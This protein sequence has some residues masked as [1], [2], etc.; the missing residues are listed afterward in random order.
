M[1]PAAQVD[2]IAFAV[3]GHRLAGRDGGDQ[4]GLVPLALALEEL[5]RLVARPHF[6]ADRDVAFGEFAHALFDGGQVVRGEGPAVGEVVVEAV[7]DHRTNRHLRVREQLLH[8]VGQQVRGRVTDDVEAVGVALGNNGE[9]GVA[10]DHV[11]GVDQPAVHLAGQRRTREPGADVARHRRHADRLRVAA[12]GAIGQANVG[13]G[14]SGSKKRM[15]RVGS[16]DEQ[17]ARAVAPRGAQ[18]TMRHPLPLA[19]N[20]PQDPP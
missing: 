4:L 15:P 20:R 16:R 8:R 12:D 5:D 10:V 2:E 9:L 11:R 3:Q 7:V 14:A 17:A 19:P 18:I 13:H 6:A 1:R